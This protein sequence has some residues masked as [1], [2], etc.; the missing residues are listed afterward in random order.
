LRLTASVGVNPAGRVSATTTG[1]LVAAPPTLATI[2]MISFFVE[3]G[4][5]WV[6]SGVALIE[7]AG[8]PMPVFASSVTVAAPPPSTL[9]ATS[10]LSGLP[11]LSSP[12]ISTRRGVSSSER[13][14]LIE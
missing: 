6:G 9:A 11:F 2:S 10:Q 13:V 14:A 8:T 1:P 12:K 3:P 4:A 7:R 5:K